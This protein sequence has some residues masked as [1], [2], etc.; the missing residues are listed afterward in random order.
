MCH[1]ARVLTP[2]ADESTEAASLAGGGERGGS[3]GIRRA[4]GNALGAVWLGIVW[5]AVLWTLLPAE[6]R[7]ATPRVLVPM[8]GVENEIGQMPG[9]GPGGVRRWA[10]ANEVLV[11]LR[12]EAQV[13][14]PA[15]LAGVPGQVRWLAPRS[16]PRVGLAGGAERGRGV[17]ESLATVTLPPGRP[18]EDWV[19]ELARHPDVLYAEPNQRLTLFPTCQEDRAPGNSCFSSKPRGAGA[20]MHFS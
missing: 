11:R 8:P 1:S 20:G 14:R 13:R 12:P 10:V 16:V 18:L 19:A 7:A 5:W 6:S 4:P 2:P 15:S 3:P 9:P 17:W